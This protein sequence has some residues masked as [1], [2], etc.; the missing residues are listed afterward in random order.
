MSADRL[1]VVIFGA[2]GFT[3][4][5]AV[6]KSV[7][8]LSKVKWGIAGRNQSK[9]EGVRERIGTKVSKDLSEIPIIIAD[10]GDE[11][12]LK[13][14]AEQAKVVVNC[15]GPY[16]HF[17]E[18][19]VKA[20]IAAGT[21]HVDVSGEPQ[22]MERMQLE[23]DEAAREAGVYVV[24]A[25]GFD[26]IPADL[27]TLFHERHF[28]GVVNS[29]ETYLV[30]KSTGP[31]ASL[32][33][34][35]WESAIYG[36]AHA[37]ELRS[38][39][40]KLFKERLPS[41][42]PSL[43]NRPIF[44]RAPVVRNAVCLPFLGSD[45]SVV[46]RSQRFLFETQKKR[47]VQVRTYMSVGTYF[48]ALLFIL[49][50]AIFSLFT[51]FS[52]GR[53]LL[54]DYPKLFSFGFASHEGPS[55][56]KMKNTKFTMWFQGAG[57]PEALAEGEDQ[58]ADPPTKKLVTKVSGTDFGY[59]NTAACI[60]LCATTILKEHSKMPGKGGVLAPG[61]AFGKT[62]LIDELNKNDVFTF[63]VVSAKED[64]QN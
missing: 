4:N 41:M 2:T 55:E 26:S 46:M 17:G 15:C 9:L 31:G 45:R 19:V 16:R 13:K 22:Y 5:C 47:P 53:R 23:Y 44:H 59:G 25:C 63:E 48:T 1:D 8:F 49:A 35:T 6:E 50:G 33:Y 34:G 64:S 51:R 42:K 61:A 43:K 11:E 60:L 37:N 62:S 30:A 7:E 18:A 21:H 28:E 40:S 14:M 52:L 24:S 54:L 32:H 3:G 36:L 12:S 39:R 10:V 57:W 27:G 56:E 38:L 58:Y 29:V 20:C